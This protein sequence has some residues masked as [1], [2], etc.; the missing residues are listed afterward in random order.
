MCQFLCRHKLI[1]SAEAG[2]SNQGENLFQQLQY[3]LSATRAPSTLVFVPTS[4][5]VKETTERIREFCVHA[6]S[7]LPLSNQEPNVTAIAVYE[8][9]HEAQSPHDAHQRRAEMLSLFENATPQ[10]PVVGVMN[11]DAVRGIDIPR[12]NLACLVGTPRT[13][14]DYLHIAGRVGRN[15]EAGTVVVFAYDA[16]QRRRCELMA[17][18]LNL[19]MSSFPS[20]ETRT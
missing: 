8:H 19:R 9:V 5:P 12:V 6:E 4:V 16:L 13:H 11:M 3:V 20:S 17:K 10:A 15:G 1:H 14:I 7:P 18:K 2:A